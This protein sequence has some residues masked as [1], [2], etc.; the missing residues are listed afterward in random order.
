MS[1]EEDK[2]G[3]G[4]QVQRQEHGRL[5]GGEGRGSERKEAGGQVKLDGG[6]VLEGC[7]EMTIFKN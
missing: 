3:E 5:R 4:A 7:P 1:C 6:W 2:T